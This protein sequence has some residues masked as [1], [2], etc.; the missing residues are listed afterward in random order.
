ML[1][2]VISGPAVVVVASLITAYIAIVGQ[3]PVLLREEVPAEHAKPGVADTMT[4]AVQ[5]RNHAATP[6]KDDKP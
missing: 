5:A 4:P 6:P 3:D 1:W 2:L